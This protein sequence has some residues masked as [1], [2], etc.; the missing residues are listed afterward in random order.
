MVDKSKQNVVQQPHGYHFGGPYGT[1]GISVILPILVYVFAFACNDVSGCPAPSLLHPE[2]L[3]LAQLKSDVGWP[4]E[5]IWGL[6]SVKVTGAVLGYYLFNA[7]LYRFLPATEV[8]GV[9]L[10]SGGK[11]KYRFNSFSS[12]M[13]IL[14]ICLAGT[15]SQG[16]EFPVWTFITDNYIQVVTANM[17]VAFA[18]ATF[19]YVRSFSVSP[20]N[21][22]NRELAEGGHSGNLVY[23]W[24][25]GRELN[26]RVNIP[27]IGEIDIKVF[28]EIRPG[29]LGWTLVNFAWVARQYRTYGFVSNSIAFV[30]FSQLVYVV[31]CWWNEP[32]ILTTIDIITDGFGFML[33]FGDV[34]WLPFMYSLQTKYLA[35]YPVSVSPFGLVGIFSIIGGAFYI[36]RASNSQKNTFRNNPSDPSVAS[37]EYIETKAGTRLLV[38]GWWGV[39]RHI[40]YLGDWLQAWP[41]SLPVGMAG[42]QIVSAGSG[43]VQSGAE[44]VFKM[45]DGREVIQGEARG[46]GIPFTYFYVLYFAILLIHRDRR[47]DEKCARKYGEDWEKYKRIVRW[48]IL[49]GIY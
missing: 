5:G 26:P 21:V 4:E 28:M 40:N 14:A 8:E 39:A 16:A 3:T 31:D 1:F 23:D 6:G 37:L 29:L 27:I 44:G 10:A 47:D 43:Y 17:L 35:V 30:S 2:N 34:A 13:F 9:Q 36:F 22:E 25:I 11:L 18:S 20:G 12:S 41:Y 42:Y 45:A 33:A 46:W 7:L 32:A 38:S 48:R 19:V 24:F 49:P 15:V